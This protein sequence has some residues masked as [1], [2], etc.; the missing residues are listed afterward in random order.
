MTPLAA[1]ERFAASATLARFALS[2]LAVLLAYGLVALI[3]AP[4]EAAI[5]D[6]GCAGL[7]C[8][9]PTRPD[10]RQA[11]YGAA[12]F[13][14]YL[15]A[16]WGI[17]GRALLGLLADLPLIA[18]VTAALL[19]AAG[20]AGHG[21]PMSD[22]TARLMVGMPLAYGAVDV[23]ENIGLAVAYA[24]LVDMAPVLPWLTAMKFGTAVASGAVSL[25]MGLMRAI[26]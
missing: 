18:A 10:T 8:L 25:I 3:H 9:R 7:E 22:R 26:A 2:L 19:C 14:L 1:A 16:I 24:G 12:E 4:I 20:L 6:G 17:R 11:G 15:D 13:R 23:L 5:R 21:I